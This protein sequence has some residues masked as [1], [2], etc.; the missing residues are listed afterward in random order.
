MSDSP[1]RDLL[2]RHEG[3]RLKPYTDTVGKI[4]IGVG[5]NLSDCGISTDEAYTLLAN[6]MDR[7]RCE[8]DKALPWHIKLDEVRHAVLLS[9]CFNLGITKLL[10]FKTTLGLIEDGKYYQAADRLLTTPWASQVGPRAVELTAMLKTGAWPSWI[11]SAS[12]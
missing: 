4:T 12:S 8:L 6:D 11:A 2:V 10:S 9:L 5:R 3:L 7:C 1:V